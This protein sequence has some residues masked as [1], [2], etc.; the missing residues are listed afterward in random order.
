MPGV[1]V[2]YVVQADT[3]EAVLHLTEVGE[4]NTAEAV[5]ASVALP[6]VGVSFGYCSVAVLAILDPAGI[7]ELPVL[8]CGSWRG[9][10]S[11]N[12]DSHRS[13]DQ[14]RRGLTLDAHT[15]PVSAVCTVVSPRY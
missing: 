6:L 8:H 15:H 2:I 13:G 5:A 9:G 4:V 12:A 1:R 11:D 7:V 10:D 14:N 3:A